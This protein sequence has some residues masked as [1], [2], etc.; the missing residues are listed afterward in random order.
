M[1]KKVE[2]LQDIYRDDDG[3]I[4]NRNVSDRQR[5]RIAKKQAM[6][7]IDTQYELQ[8]IKEEVHELA[9]LREEVGELKDLLKELLGKK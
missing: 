2:G 1:K 9:S 6:Q 3:T 4:V 7:T 5:Y 8:E